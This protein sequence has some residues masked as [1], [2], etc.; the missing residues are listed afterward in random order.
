VVGDSGFPSGHSKKIGN[1]RDG[2][3]KYGRIFVFPVE[4]KGYTYN[5]KIPQ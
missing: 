2:Y 4:T 5:I 3:A 1:I